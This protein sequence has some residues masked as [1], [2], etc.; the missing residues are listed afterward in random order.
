[1]GN[2]LMELT[3][4]AVLANLATAGLC[5]TMNWTNAFQSLAKIM[6]SVKPSMDKQCVHAKINFWVVHVK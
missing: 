3:H 4:L 6:E 1:M 2:V 5:A